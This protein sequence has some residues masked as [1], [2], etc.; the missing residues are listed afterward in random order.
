MPPCLT[1]INI[2]YGSRVKWSNPGKGV[3]PSPTPW[4]SSYQKGSP[5]VTLDYDNSIVSF[6]KGSVRVT[7]DYGRLL[8]LLIYVYEHYVYFT[9]PYHWYVK[10]APM[11]LELTLTD[12]LAKFTKYYTTQGAQINNMYIK[13]EYLS[14]VIYSYF[15]NWIS[16][17]L[18]LAI[19][20]S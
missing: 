16:I 17:L 7:L 3:A 20:N 4:C 15:G 11:R 13:I 5:W 10:G 14:S 9:N 1:L 2:R 8:Y 12:L 6:R 19:N 18:F